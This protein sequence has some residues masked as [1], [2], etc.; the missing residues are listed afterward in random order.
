MMKRGK[1][2]SMSDIL[3]TFHDYHEIVHFLNH[4]LVAPIHLPICQNQIVAIFHILQCCHQYVLSFQSWLHLLMPGLNF[5]LLL[6]ISGNP[7]KTLFDH[8]NLHCFVY[9]LILVSAMIASLAESSG[10]YSYPSDCDY[11][12]NILTI[13]GK[14]KSSWS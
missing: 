2:N 5:G 3:L 4:C 8:P 1:R 6:L 11:C 13:H 9:G 12:E 14:I 10:L 7:S